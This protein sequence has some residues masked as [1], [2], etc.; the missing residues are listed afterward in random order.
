MSILLC[1]CTVELG[2]ILLG[3][4]ASQHISGYIRWKQNRKWIFLLVLLHSKHTLEEEG[5]EEGE[6]EEEDEGKEGEEGSKRK[7]KRIGG[8]QGGG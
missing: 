8:G 3:E 7:R 1:F 6:E 4:P 5:E 2:N